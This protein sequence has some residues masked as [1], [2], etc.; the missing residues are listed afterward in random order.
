MIT[1]KDEQKIKN[2]IREELKEALFRKITIERGPDKQGDPEKRVA[3]EEWNVLDFLAVYLPKVEGALRGAQADVDRTK[4]QV[5]KQNKQ[6]EAVGNTLLSM[7]G[8]AMELAKLSDVI[9]KLKLPSPVS[10]STEFI[11]N[12]SDN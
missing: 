1:K 3:E 10:V 9:K 4:N 8:S 7:E 6:I 12:E 5:L 2:I 11:E